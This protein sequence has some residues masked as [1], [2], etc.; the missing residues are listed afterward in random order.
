MKNNTNLKFSSWSRIFSFL[1]YF[2]ITWGVF[3]IIITVLTNTSEDK[4]L[5]NIFLWINISIVLNIFFFIVN[6]ILYKFFGGDIGK[7]ICGIKVQNGDMENLSFRDFL[8]REFIG[9]IFSSLFL[10]LGY[11][12]IFINKKSQG[13]H[14]IL[15]ETFVYRGSIKRVA[16]G[17]LMSF[18]FFIVSIVLLNN[19]IQNNKIFIKMQNHI[20]ILEN[21]NKKNIPKNYEE[22]FQS[23]LK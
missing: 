17:T 8:F 11:F 1:S 16:L 7:L 23:F 19:F 15:S 2:F 3:N 5:G 22:K 18:I 20:K 4:S 12:Y 9:K 14:D 6:A 13:F 10:F 21:E